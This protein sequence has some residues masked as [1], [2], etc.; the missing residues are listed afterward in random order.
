MKV[1][2]D[3]GSNLNHINMSMISALRFAVG[4]SLFSCSQGLVYLLESGAKIHSELHYAVM[5]GLTH[6]VKQFLSYKALPEAINAHHFIP[7]L[8]NEKNLSPL[9]VALIADRV[10]LAK[11]FLDI[12]FLADIDLTILNRNQS[13]RRYLKDKSRG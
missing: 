5:L 4:Q 7:S 2:I 11:F 12:V 6:V 10:E 13:F 8:P 1:L 3:A 9:C